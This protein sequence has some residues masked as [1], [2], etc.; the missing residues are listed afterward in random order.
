MSPIRNTPLRCEFK[1]GDGSVVPLKFLKKGNRLIVG[2][3]PDNRLF[4]WD[5]ESNRQIQSWPAPA[6]FAGGLGVSPDERL[7]VAVGVKGQVVCRDLQSH[8]ST[9]LPLAA[10]TRT[11]R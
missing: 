5:L 7:A 6:R 3:G 4:E 8:T 9:N 10:V 11:M 2:S 1:G